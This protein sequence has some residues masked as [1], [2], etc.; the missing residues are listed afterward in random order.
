MPIKQRIM[1]FLTTLFIA[2][3]LSAPSF[4]ADSGVTNSANAAGGANFEEL[5][6]LLRKNLTGVSDAELEQAA[7]QG[8]IKQLHPLVAIATNG[9]RHANGT[10]GGPLAATS[11]LEGTFA[12]F[13][14]NEIAEGA[15]KEFSSALKRIGSTNKLRGLVLDLRFARGFDYSAAAALADP[16]LPPRQPVI[17]WGDGV[18]LSTAK[19]NP[20]HLPVAILI[21]KETR[22]AAEAFAAVLRRS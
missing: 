2:L 7:V 3:L 4:A 8:L 12:Y 16:F 9:G 13:R 20:V 21:N 11:V 1:K 19:T 15:D 10:N 6:D 14:F 17:D 18:K 22:G 5:Y